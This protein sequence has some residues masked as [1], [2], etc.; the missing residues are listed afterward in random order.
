MDMLC[1]EDLV[2]MSEQGWKMGSSGALKSTGV[3][4]MMSTEK[5][6]G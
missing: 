6:N 1:T 5:Q 2:G 4:I 3:Y